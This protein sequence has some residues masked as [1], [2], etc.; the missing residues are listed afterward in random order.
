MKNKTLAAWL[1]FVGG[2]LGLHR[3]YL[4]GTADRLAWMLPIPSLLGLYGVYRARAIGLED[5]ASWLLIPLLGFTLA[6]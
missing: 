3:F 1:C 6:A 4:F 2:P 5:T